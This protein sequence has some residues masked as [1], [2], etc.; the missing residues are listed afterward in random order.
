LDLGS[1]LLGSDLQI[2]MG[3]SQFISLLDGPT[4]GGSDRRVT[5]GIK[6]GDVDEDGREDG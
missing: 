6:K 2:Y 1:D 4:G 5:M 3:G